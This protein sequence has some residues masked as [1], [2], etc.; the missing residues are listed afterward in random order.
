M[1]HLAVAD[2]ERPH[3]DVPVLIHNALTDLVDVD[4]I[5]TV[6]VLGEIPL[7][8]FGADSDVL[9]PRL[10]D[11]VGHGLDATRPVDL[12]GTGSTDDP[13]RK[14]EIRV[15]DRVIRM[16]MRHEGGLEL[17]EVE[18]LYSLSVGGRGAADNARAEIDKVGSVVD[19]DGDA[20]PG[21]IG[22]RTWSARSQQDDLRDL[23]WSVVR[24][25]EGGLRSRQDH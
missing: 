15:S 24:F 25:R 22:D 19:N 20:R 1:W 7:H 14:N 10:E 21:A 23:G 9:F 2:G 13:R 11:V 4:L 3:R 5:S 18:A 6:I 12:N 17:R 8:A 16:Q